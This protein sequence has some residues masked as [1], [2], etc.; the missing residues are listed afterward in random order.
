MPSRSAKYCALYLDSVLR[1]NLATDVLLFRAIDKYTVFPL[2]FFFSLSLFL[3]FFLP[4]FPSLFS[5]ANEII[6]SIRQ[7][8]GNEEKKDRWEKNNRIKYLKY[9]IR[10]ERKLWREK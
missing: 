5:L 10:G 9:L 1:I 3:S 4:L 8:I 7:I 6:S 2:F